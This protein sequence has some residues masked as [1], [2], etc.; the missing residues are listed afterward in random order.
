MLEIHSEA[1]ATILLQKTSQTASTKSY[2]K[3]DNCFAQHGNSS[4][5]HAGNGVSFLN[6]PHVSALSSTQQRKWDPQTVQDL[7]DK[8]GE[9]FAPS[10]NR[11]AASHL[12]AQYILSRSD[13]LTHKQIV[14]MFSGFCPVSGSPLREPRKESR[15]KS[16]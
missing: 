7:A 6:P 16:T 12:W 11:N 15:Y 9:I 4:S 1:E 14:H 10:N 2:A 5:T 3:S 13:Q 8:Y